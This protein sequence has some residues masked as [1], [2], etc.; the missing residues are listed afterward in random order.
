MLFRKLCSAVAATAMS[1]IVNQSP[2]HAGVLDNSVTG[3]VSDGNASI[4]YRLFTPQDTAVGQKVPLILY[5]H[6]MGE[7]GTD[8]TAQTSWIGNLT[9][10]TSSGQYA[11]YVLAPQIDTNMWFAS[12][13]STPTEAMS[14]TMTA[15]H[16]A[17]NNP[18]VDTSRVYVTGASM[19]AFGTW[20]IL[21]KDPGVFAAAV[22]MS[23]G[24]DPSTASEIASTPIW[25]FHGS[26]DSVVSVDTTRNM[27]AALQ[28]AGGSPNYTEI[29]GGD[30]AIWPNVFADAGNTLYPWL[31]SQHL[32]D[33]L[34][35][36]ASSDF[37]S[38]SSYS[39]VGPAPVAVISAVPE[40]TGLAIVSLGGIA[41]LVR[42]KRAVAVSL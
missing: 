16:Q 19:G 11:A 40:P 35:S 4:P 32:G 18:S 26:A 41:L 25:A 38:T 39:A 20:D 13:T 31:F 29:E 42:R 17:M 14:L 15:L 28:A 7:R 37:A 23:G 30:H 8:N 6:G 21:R 12:S 9:S 3:T 22:P 10:K 5:L 1:L 2:V 36:A 34:D 24:G 27:I 33:S